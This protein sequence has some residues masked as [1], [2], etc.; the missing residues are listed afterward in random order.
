[1]GGDQHV[2]ALVGE[3]LDKEKGDEIR[4]TREPIYK[5]LMG[6]VEPSRTRTS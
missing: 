6:E 3:A 5:E 2:P 1:M 4:K